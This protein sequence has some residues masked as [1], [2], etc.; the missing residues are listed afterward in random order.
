MVSQ[1]SHQTHETASLAHWISGTS[2]E[3]IFPPSHV[4]VVV[5]LS[6]VDGFAVVVLFEKVWE[7]DSGGDGVIGTGNCISGL[8]R[9]EIEGFGFTYPHCVI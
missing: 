3:E 2:S 4:T 8:L 5:Q 6:K 9:S 7:V 1:R